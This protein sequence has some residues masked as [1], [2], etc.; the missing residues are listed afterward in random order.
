M[1]LILIKNKTSTKTTNIL[2][3]KNN[4]THATTHIHSNRKSKKNVHG[5]Q[6][7]IYDI[8]IQYQELDKGMLVANTL[9]GKLK[10]QHL[11]NTSW[12]V[13]M[14]KAILRTLIQK[15]EK[16]IFSFRITHEAA[17]SNSKILASFNSDLGAA[18]GA[19]KEIPVNYGSEFCNIAS[20]EKLFLHHEDK[21]NIINII[22]QGSCYH[23][24]LVKEET[25]KPD[26]D[27]M[28]LRGNHKSSHSLLN[29]AA[30]Y[31]A[32]SKEIDRGWALPLTIES[33]QKIKNAGVMH[34][35]VAE[36]FSIN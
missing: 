13:T 27:A 10:S 9:K 4:I 22:R 14:I 25:R 15:F 19:H 12:L 11:T 26:S 31:K 18:I 23:L 33:L 24:T 35:G 28:I 1:S 3:P 8:N 29:L 21:T 5:N 2:I 20:L 7:S 16:P 6:K 30:L 34:L 36:Q 32:I 17:V